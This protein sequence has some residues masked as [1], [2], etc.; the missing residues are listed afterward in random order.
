MV[1]GT[2]VTAVYSADK[3]PEEMEEKNTNFLK[4]KIDSI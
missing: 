4:S 1:P 3:I 2:V